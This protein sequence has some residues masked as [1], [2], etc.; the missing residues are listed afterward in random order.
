M[1]AITTA[2]APGAANAAPKT[3]D[4]AVEQTPHGPI[5]VQLS[6]AGTRITAVTELQTPS[7]RGR[8]VEVNAQAAPVLAREVLSSQCAKIDTVSG[9]TYASDGYAQSVQSAIDKS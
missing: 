7:D 8:S 1:S 9:A 2:S 5:Q 3:V 6:Y 4:G